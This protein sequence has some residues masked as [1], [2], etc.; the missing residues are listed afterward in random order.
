MNIHLGI[1]LACI[2]G[3]L[4]GLDEGADMYPGG[5]R[6][7]P[8]FSIYHRVH[9]FLKL[10][11]VAWFGH[12]FFGM[13]GMWCIPALILANRFAEAGYGWS[14]YRDMF[15]DNE[16]FMGYLTITK[17]GLPYIRLLLWTIGAV[18]WVKFT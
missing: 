3:L 7:S 2:A 11:F 9:V 10:I 1:I 14:R 15:P 8:D 5:V 18:T 6:C 13:F 12:Y 17:P 4:H 16:N